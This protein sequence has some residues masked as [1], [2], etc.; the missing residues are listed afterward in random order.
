MERAKK[1]WE[2]S[3]LR[4][5]LFILLLSLLIN[6]GTLVLIHE[7]PRRGIITLE[8]LKSH[9]FLQPT[10]LGIPYFRKPPLHEW[11]TSLFSLLS[12]QVC[13]FSLRVPSALAAILTSVLIFTGIKHIL[14]KRIALFGSLIYATFY[15]V[16]IGYSSKC[17]PD[18]LFSLLV[19]LSIF[20][21]LWFFSTGRE[22]AGW[23]TGYFFTS[24]ALLTKG[25]PALQ[26][27]WFFTLV[28]LSVKKEMNKLLSLK[29]VSGLLL[30]LSPFFLWI[31][32]VKTDQ[33]AKTLFSEVISRAPGEVSLTKSLKNYATYPFRL[34]A[35]TFPWSLIF[36]Y[37]L[38]REKKPIVP[39]DETVKIFL[40]TFSVDALLYWLF[41]GSRL[42]YLI[43][44][45]PLLAVFLGYYLSDYRLIHKRAKE[46]IRFTAEIIVPVAIVVG[47]VVSRNPSLILK[48]TLEFLVILYAVYFLLLPRVNFTYVTVLFSLLMLILRGFFSSYYYPIAQLRYPPVREVAR[49][50]VKDSRGYPLYTKTRYLQLCFYVEKWKNSILKFSTSPPA[51]ALFI[52]RRP[53]GHVLKEYKLGRH[54]FYLCSTSTPAQK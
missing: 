6:I 46:I 24:L 33:A 16:L 15:I 49:E 35:A 4:W 26:F 21:W 9:S 52:S 45:L 39:K 18:A 13:E 50:I 42:R 7:E 47:I 22:F 2:S 36:L 20:S 5:F 43:P 23:V 41:P 32:A 44:A 48:S 54:R 17:E 34:V 19:S 38:Y 27:F 12:G 30:G 8:M 11:I 25:L 10:V 28:Y 14:G 40:I 51:N 53:E 31:T 3:F 29:H 37:Y 1:N